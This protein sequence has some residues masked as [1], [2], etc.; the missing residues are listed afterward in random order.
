MEV[1]SFKFLSVPIESVI[2][3]LTIDDSLLETVK[4]KPKLTIPENPDCD[5]DQVTDKYY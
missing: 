4:K 5:L 1:D 2:S 3:N